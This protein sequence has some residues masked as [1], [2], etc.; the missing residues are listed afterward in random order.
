VIS[1]IGYRP[2]FDHLGKE[3]LGE[4]FSDKEWTCAD[5]ATL[6]QTLDD[7][8]RVIPEGEHWNLHYSTH[9]VLPGVGRPFQKCTNYIFDVDKIAGYMPSMAEKVAK[10]TC[11]FFKLDECKTAVV[12]SGNGVHVIVALMPEYH[13]SEDSRYREIWPHYKAA[14]EN[15]TDHLRKNGFPGCV[16]DPQP[17]NI[18]GT[19]RLPGTKNVKKTGTTDCTLVQKVL[20]PQNFD[21]TKFSGLG[22]LP[23]GEA[24]PFKEL[25]KFP[26]PD[27][28]AVLEGCGFLKHCKEN[29]SEVSEP[30]WYAMLSI[31]GRVSKDRAECDKLVHEYSCKHPSYDADDTNRKLTHALS[32]GP[33]TCKGIND[34]WRNSQCVK[35]PHWGEVSS[36]IVIKGK[37]YI[38]TEGTGFWIY[39][40]TK[41]GNKIDKP[42]LEGLRLY[43]ERQ[44][45]Y[46]SAHDSGALYIWENK[47]WRETTDIEVKAFAHKM[48]D[49]KPDRDAPRQEFL[50]RIQVTNVCVQEW[51]RENSVRKMNFQNGVLDLDTM[52]MSENSPK[53]G[54]MTVLPYSYDPEARAPHFEKFLDDVTL[55]REELKETLLEFAGYSL[56]GDKCWEQK[57]MILL[58]EGQNGKSK[59]VQILRELAGSSAVSALSLSDLDDEKNR[60]QLEKSLFNV[61]EETP[62]YLVDSSIFKNLV[63]GGDI[64]AK[65]LYENSYTMR[66]KAKFWFLCNE[67][68]K[69]YD[70][71]HGMFRRLVIVPFDATF[72]GK[73]ED[74]HIEQKLLPELPGILNMCLAAY[75]RMQ[76]RGSLIKSEVVANRLREYKEDVDVV[77]RWVKDN[78]EILPEINGKYTA[79]KVIYG[80]YSNDMRLE[81]EKPI[82]ECPFL[83][84]VAKI[85]PDYQKRQDRIT[86]NGAKVSIIRG[87]VMHDGSMF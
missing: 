52:E 62:K 66:N 56:S 26:P 41:D 55:G 27:T 58:G 82:P 81:N 53:H 87:V 39:K 30:E 77:R 71:T 63:S 32:V 42:D 15:L 80:K 47:V 67:L 2:Y 13:F 72:S 51:F 60:F 12:N 20:L 49:P 61:S 36:P 10:L 4:K 5:H 79:S 11:E 83:R 34:V 33:R 24:V 21:I 7:V 31:V 84:R 3:R 29:Q 85:I 57:A 54:F 1:I 14:C 73:N 6:F 22:E 68:P 44:T 74:K 8:L 25:K 19:S 69:T 86:E 48:F 16:V 76:K 78:L 37:D 28:N 50:K 45:P 64:L 43:Y 46:K 18:R 17:W 70:F 59:F 40:W 23:P 9:H 65:K 38:A 75:F 35:C